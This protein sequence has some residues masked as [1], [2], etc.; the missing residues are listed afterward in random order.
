[1]SLNGY[2]IILASGSPRRVELLKKLGLN[3]SIKVPKIRE[4]VSK[5]VSPQKYV[6][7][8]AE[9][10][11]QKIAREV[12]G[13]IILGADTIVVLKNQILGKPKNR[14]DAFRILKLLSGRKHKVYTGVHLINSY[15]NKSLSDFECTRV[16][17]RRLH[18]DKIWEYIDS[19]EPLDKAGA[20]GI[21]GMGNFLVDYLEGD[22]D[23]V[24]GLP[25]K[26]VK[27]MLQKLLN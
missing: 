2:K 25:V 3:F 7:R 14:K 4:S 6:L 11:A 19:L 26:K 5:A 1:M 22:L 20:Y 27:S 18:D 8:I 9:K 24:I 23:N 15:N 12:K 10:K 13:G 16:K 21:Q 17:F